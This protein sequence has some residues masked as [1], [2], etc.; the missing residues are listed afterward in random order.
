M[1]LE[2]TEFQKS[3]LNAQYVQN[4]LL[5][6]KRHFNRLFNDSFV[7]YEPL[8]LLSGDFF[9]V[10]KKYNMRYLVVGDCT[11]H[12]VSASL[13]SVLALNL[14][15]YCIM[16][17]GIKRTSRILSEVDKRFIES[18]KG[19]DKETFDNPWIDLSIVCIDDD[20]KKIYFSSANRKMLYVN[21][22]GESQ[23]YKSS[24][25]PI[26]GWQIQSNRV[27]ETTVI[28]F[29]E[30]DRVY[31]GSDGFQDQFGG[32]KN[33]KYGSKRLHELL[34]RNSSLSFNLQKKALVD[35]LNCW[36]DEEP[37]TDDICLV[38]VEL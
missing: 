8:D 23:V 27:F 34:T 33:K 24:G 10:G 20:L 13:T 31:L 12:G 16:N 5:P 21:K 29:E 19:S 32:P 6:K 28:S 2:R 25:Y 17:K 3:M 15:E 11:G 4:G 35:E 9:W 36:K 22:H 14:F 30:G 1:I 38:G 18:F 37:Q 7:L 26:G